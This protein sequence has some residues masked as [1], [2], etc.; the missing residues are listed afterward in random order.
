MG[1]RAASL[2]L[3]MSPAHGIRRAALENDLPWRAVLSTQV[4]HLPP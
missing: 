3:H 4:T 2:I 1:L